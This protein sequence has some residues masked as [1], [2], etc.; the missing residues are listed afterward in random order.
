MLKFNLT[1]KK[2]GHLKVIKKS[3]KK[4]K[5][6]AVF[7]KC[8]CACGK[9]TD[10]RTGHLNSGSTTSC[11]CNPGSL[12]HARKGQERPEYRA[13]LAMKTRCY[14]SNSK[15]YENYGARGIKVCDRW[16]KS[17]KAFYEDMGE[18]PDGNYSIERVDVN[19]GYTP[20]NC[21]WAN[22]TVQNRNTRK[23]KS[24][25][26]GCKGVHWNS[27]HKKW[28]ARISV[29]YK[30]ISLGYYDNLEEAKNARKKG[31]EKYW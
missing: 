22:K 9:Y 28:S 23:K 17:Y 5:Y 4:D 27:G 31:E 16:L 8:L 15:D 11:G 18:R 3:D 14:N 1:G 30:R 13:W 10:V 26:S 24:N 7:W 21:I 12:K 29:N 2:F 25:T 20:E 6:G 19:K